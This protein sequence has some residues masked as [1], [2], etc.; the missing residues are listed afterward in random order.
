VTRAAREAAADPRFSIEERYGD[1]AR[2]QAL[3]SDR[4]DNLVRDGY[5]LSEDVAAV[6]ERALARWDE[7]TRGTPLATR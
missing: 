2:Y 1:R 7:V 3:V 5:L 6:V 4:A